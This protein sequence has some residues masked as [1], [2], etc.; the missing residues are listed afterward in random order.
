M[1]KTSIQESVIDSSKVSGRQESFVSG[2]IESTVDAS[3]WINQVV[4]TEKYSVPDS[5]GRQHVTER[6]VKTSSRR[7]ESSATLSQTKEEKQLEQIDSSAYHAEINELNDEEELKVPCVSSRGA[8]WY[9]V[10]AALFV[11]A[12]IGIILGARIGLAFR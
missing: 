3:S 11:G 10:I 6:T 12:L 9:V 4:V 1:A 7:A 8:P 5:A 2:T